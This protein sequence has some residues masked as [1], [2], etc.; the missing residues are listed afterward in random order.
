M[1]AFKLPNASACKLTVTT[2][3]QSLQELIATAAG[4]D[5]VDFKFRPWST[6]N[7]ID[8]FVESGSIRWLDDGN[9]PTASLGHIASDI[10]VNTISLEEISLP[11]LQFISADGVNATITFRMYRL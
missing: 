7:S 2:T 9:T 4:T 10:G 6:A 1:R 5:E 11:D 3:A 8:I